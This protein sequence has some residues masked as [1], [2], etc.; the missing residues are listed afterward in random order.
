MIDGG[1]EDGYKATPCF[2]GS[3]P[4]SLVRLFLARQD[5]SQHKVLDLGCGEGKNAHAFAL[6]GA[7]VDAVDCSSKAIENGRI[8]FPSS[9]I[10]WHIADARSWEGED[11]SYDVIISYG[12]LHCM[13][14]EA[15]AAALISNMSKMTKCGGYNI[16]CTFNDRRHDLTAHPGFSPLLAGH[17]WYLG[18]Y[19]GWQITDASDSDLF[20][21]HPHN[22]IPHYHSMTRLIARKTG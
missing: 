21:T 19:A 17:G 10:S 5:V 4:A 3:A 15:D 11:D 18:Q 14:N 8:A 22:Q 12:V 9:N 20:E 7:R 16:I 6:N 13:R 2:W 1:Y